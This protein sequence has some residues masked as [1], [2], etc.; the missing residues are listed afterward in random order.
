MVAGYN[1]IV[2]EH[3]HNV[4]FHFAAKDVE[5]EVALYVV[6]GINE[7]CMFFGAANAVDY[8]FHSSRAA[9]VF[10]FFDS[11]VTVYVVAMYNHEI[12]RLGNRRNCQCGDD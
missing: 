8:D 3:V 9:I 2:A 5:V 7:Q 1:D 10:D 4:V 11:H 12:F 6:A